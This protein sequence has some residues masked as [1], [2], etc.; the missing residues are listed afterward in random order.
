MPGLFASIPGWGSYTNGFASGHG[1]SGQRERDDN[2]GCSEN[3]LGDAVH[4]RMLARHPVG[5]QPSSI[6]TRSDDPAQ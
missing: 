4:M 1:A 3:G 5:D 6:C 2:D